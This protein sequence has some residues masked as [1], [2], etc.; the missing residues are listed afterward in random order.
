LCLRDKVHL[1]MTFSQIISDPIIT[2]TG[3]TDPKQDDD[4]LKI[5][6]CTLLSLIILK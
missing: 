3:I 2:I 5:L 4:D 1:N 6:F